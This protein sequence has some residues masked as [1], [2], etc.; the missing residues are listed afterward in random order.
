MHFSVATAA[1]YTSGAF[2]SRMRVAAPGAGGVSPAL[3]TSILT[4]VVD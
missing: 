2:I 1:A 3:Q 4:G